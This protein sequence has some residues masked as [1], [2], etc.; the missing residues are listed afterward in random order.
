MPLYRD[1]RLAK[2]TREGTFE[3]SPSSL[4]LNWRL[5]EQENGK[6]ISSSSFLKTN[7]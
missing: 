2:S 6:V 1:I 4:F 3:E 7:A 5:N